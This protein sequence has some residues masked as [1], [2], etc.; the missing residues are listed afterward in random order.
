MQLTSTVGEHY[1][2]SPFDVMKQ[3]TDQVIMVINF[4][5]DKSEEKTDIHTNNIRQQTKR[6]EVNDATASGGWY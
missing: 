4:L 5:L 6:I 2:L 1:R 3:D